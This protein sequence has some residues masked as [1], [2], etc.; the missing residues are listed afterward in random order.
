VKSSKSKRKA[1]ETAADIYA[2]EMGEKAHK[3]VKR[4]PKN[5]RP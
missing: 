4:G 1:G 2:Q 5:G 3:K